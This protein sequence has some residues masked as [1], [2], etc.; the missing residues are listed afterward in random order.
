MLR[1]P[2]TIF[3]SDEETLS[4]YSRV[5]LHLSP[6]TRI[7]NENPSN[8]V[9]KILVKQHRFYYLLK[10]QQSLGQQK[11]EIYYFKLKNVIFNFID[12]ILKRSWYEADRSLIPR[13]SWYVH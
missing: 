7:L 2:V 4:K 10:G 3:Y 12:W 13:C 11:V 5:T 6:A 8:S 9:I 1:Y